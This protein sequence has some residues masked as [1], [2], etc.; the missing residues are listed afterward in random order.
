MH[1]QLQGNCW[2]MDAHGY[3]NVAAFCLLAVLAG[4]GNIADEP[5]VQETAVQPVGV[6]GKVTISFAFTGE[7]AASR[8]VMP[9]LPAVDHYSVSVWPADEEE[10]LVDAQRIKWQ[11]RA[12]G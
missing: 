11:R 9:V 4:C 12:D 7:A 3:R 10:P 6:T 1:G 5:Q 8:T 2:R